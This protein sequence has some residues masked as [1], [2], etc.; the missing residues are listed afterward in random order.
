MTRLSERAK[1]PKLPHAAY[2]V[3]CYYNRAVRFAPDDTVVRALYAQ[4]LAKN[5]RVNEALSELDVAVPYAKDNPFSHYN[6]GLVYF[7]LGQFDKALAQ[8]HRAL[9]LEFEKTELSDL[10]KGVNRWREP[11]KQS[12]TLN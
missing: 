1:L 11:A 4:Y 6:I 9:E 7:D 5:G 2:S 10:L 8:A 3:E 12:R